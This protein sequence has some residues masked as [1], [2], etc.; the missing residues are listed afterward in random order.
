MN[1][2]CVV[3]VVC[4]LVHTQT[5]DAGQSVRL[6]NT[7]MPAFCRTL[8]LNA[9]V[10]A[11]PAH[12]TLMGASRVSSTKSQ[13][14]SSLTPRITTTLTCE[15]ECECTCECDCKCECQRQRQQ[16]PSCCTPARHPISLILTATTRRDECNPLTLTGLYPRRTASSIAASTR[17]WPPRRASASKRSGRSVSRLMFSAFIPAALSCVCVR[18]CVG[19]AGVG[20]LNAKLPIHGLALSAQSPACTT[21]NAPL[22]HANTCGAPAAAGA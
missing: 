12:L 13:T 19:V 11:A 4:G 5:V 16:P 2:V 6:V 14:S 1:L 3:Y 17:P 20:A 21:C 18:V 10:K 15:C 22:H 9:A 7:A 8:L